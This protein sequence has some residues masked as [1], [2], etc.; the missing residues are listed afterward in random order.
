MAGIKQALYDSGALY[1]SLTGSGSC[2]YGIYDVPPADPPLP[3]PVEST[4]LLQ[5]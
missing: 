1:A 4:Y 3:G 2:I 5:L